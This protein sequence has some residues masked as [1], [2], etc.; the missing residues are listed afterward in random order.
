MRLRAEE[1]NRSRLALRNESA[2]LRA[3]LAELPYKQTK[4]MAE[5]QRRLL[6][7]QSSLLESEVKRQVMITAPVAGEVAALGVVNGR[8]P[9]PVA[10]A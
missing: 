3:E 8:A 2:A 1:L 10:P 4:Q 6:E 5:L 7:S 9:I